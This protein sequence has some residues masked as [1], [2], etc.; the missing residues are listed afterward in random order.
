MPLRVCIV[1]DDQD[2]RESLRALFEETEAIVEE[3]EQGVAAL[4]LLER[5]PAPRVL[6]LDRLMPRLDGV[7]VLRA[8]AQFRRLSQRTAIVFMTARYEPLDAS[9]GEL[10]A[11]LHVEVLTKPFEIDVLLE[12]VERAWQRL[13]DLL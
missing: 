9:L 4:A 12:H 8:L 2:I 7:G 11:A 13:T 6:L 1:D 5:E 10:A 3:A